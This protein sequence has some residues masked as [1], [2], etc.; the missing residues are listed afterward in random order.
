MGIFRR[1]QKQHPNEYVLPSDIISMMERFGRYEFNPQAN[2][3]NGADIGQLMAELYPFASAD[4]DRA[5]C[6]QIRAG[7]HVLHA[8]EVRPPAVFRLIPVRAS[9]GGVRPRGIYRA[10]PFPPRSVPG[11]LDQE[12]LRAPVQF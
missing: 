3:D 7:D 8:P 5:I 10:V 9:S 11:H 4:P 6:V 1:R 2:A 12:S